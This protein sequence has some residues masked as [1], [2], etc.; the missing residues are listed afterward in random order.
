MSDCNLSDG[1]GECNECCS[2]EKEIERLTERVKRLES[3]LAVG[4]RVRQNDAEDFLRREGYR[5]CDVAAC[6]CGS[7]HKPTTEGFP[8]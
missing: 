6:N 1:H 2:Y 8:P 4:V 7:W 5:A 3:D